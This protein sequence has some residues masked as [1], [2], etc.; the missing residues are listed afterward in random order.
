MSASLPVWAEVQGTVNNCTN[1]SLNN[2]NRVTAT[3]ATD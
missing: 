1:I 2:N 3:S